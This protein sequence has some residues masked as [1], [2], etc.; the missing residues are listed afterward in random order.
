MKRIFI[1]VV[2]LS[3][4]ILAGCSGGTTSKKTSNLIVTVLD[5]E[6]KPISGATI[7]LDGKTG[8]TDSN[9]KYT[10]KSLEE[11]SFTIYA[12]KEGYEENS[13]S[14]N[15][16]AGKD[17]TL[18]ITL[19]KK[20]TEQ[21]SE[22]KELS[23]IKSYAFTFVTKDENGKS[24][25][26]KEEINDFGKREHLIV[27]NE[28]GEVET[29]YFLVNDKAKMKSGDEWME[30]TGEQATS[31]GGMFTSLAE[32]FSNSATSWYNEAVRVPGGS[33]TF[34]RLGTE[35][36]NGYSTTKY[37]YTLTGEKYLGGDYEKV[38]VTYW[39][40]NSGN[41]KDYTTRLIFEYTPTKNSTGSY[42]SIEFNFTRLGEDLK[43]ELPQ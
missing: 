18:T 42:Q 23:S 9:G 25:T 29:E 32:S 28:D 12:S 21:V 10:F 39:V 36:M 17:A 31:M 38:V 11:G 13:D 33:V 43:I 27:I 6:S 5:N 20:T 2:V 30:F 3:L 26:I 22:L 40:I 41:Y 1:V 34:K 35:T 15:V 7:G 24:S 16:T 19:S 4:L 37:E 8:S 14:I